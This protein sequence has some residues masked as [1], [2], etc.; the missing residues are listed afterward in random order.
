MAGEGW[1]CPRCGIVHAPWVPRCSCASGLA[2]F[3]VTVLP[4]ALSPSSRTSDPLPDR[5]RTTSDA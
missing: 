5:G 1:V 2:G 3:A 4:W